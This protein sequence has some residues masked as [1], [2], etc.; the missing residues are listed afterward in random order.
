M[1]SRSRSSAG[2]RWNAF[3]SRGVARWW[4]RSAARSTGCAGASKR[5]L[6]SCRSIERRAGLDAHQTRSTSWARSTRLRLI[7]TCCH[8]SL[9]RDAQVALTLRPL[10]GL[11]T[12]EIARAFLT[13]EPTMA[14]R[15]VRVKRRIRDEAIPF[16]VPSP[17]AMRERLE[18]RAR[19]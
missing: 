8:P 4:Q 12:A 13:T 7:F 17:D 18:R 6:G 9:P 15:L 2:P 5:W 19:R 3:E 14:Q 16:E 10:G 1:R 11:S